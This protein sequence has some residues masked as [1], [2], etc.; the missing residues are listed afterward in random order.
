MSTSPFVADPIGYARTLAVQPKLLVRRIRSLA[1]QLSL[2]SLAI[3]SACSTSIP[4]V[5]DRVPI[6][7]TTHPEPGSDEIGGMIVPVIFEG[8]EAA[9][10]IDTGSALTFLYTGKDS[11]TFTPHAGTVGIGARKL[12][13]PGRNFEAS[14]ETASRIVGVLGAEFLLDTTTEFDPVGLTITRFAA[15]ARPDTRGWIEVPLEDV[16][17]H[18]ILK[19]TFDG[20]LRRLMWDTGSPH[21]LLVGEGERSGDTSSLAEDVEGTRFPIYSGPSVLHVPG[22]PDRTITALRAPKFPYFEGTVRALGG[23]IDGLAGQSVFGHRRL[24]F[25]RSAGT[26]FIAPDESQPGSQ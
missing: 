8:R 5:L 10:A 1:R 21:A 26:L 19:L 25:C 9:L 18:I 15:D 24:L 20:R 11:A 13:L 4:Q 22:A 23:N 3:L 16:Q 14:D 6:A 7:L 17:G 12:D 2:I